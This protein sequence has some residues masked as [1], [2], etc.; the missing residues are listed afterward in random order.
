MIEPKMMDEV[1]AYCTKCKL[2]LN[3]RVTRVEGK[4]IKKALCLTCKAEHAYRKSAPAKPGEGKV[5]KPR[6]A[7]TKVDQEAE[8][9]QTLAQGSKNTKPYGMEKV[10]L[11]ND[12]VEHQL[13]G[14]GLVVDLLPPGK[15]NIFF[16]DGIKMMKCGVSP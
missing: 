6:A 13:F 7:S 15:V 5:R 11:L 10:F 8:W 9:R 1:D 12:H 2:V 3:H 16:Q 4:K 14:I